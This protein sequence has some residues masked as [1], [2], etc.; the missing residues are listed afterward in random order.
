MKP[1]ESLMSVNFSEHFRQS[2][3]NLRP[4]GG[5]CPLDSHLRSAFLGLVTLYN[6]HSG[7]SSYWYGYTEGKLRRYS[8]NINANASRNKA[9]TKLQK[10]KTNIL[11]KHVQ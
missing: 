1:F 10:Y 2:W 3:S 6:V 5:P 9:N 8:N 11:H 7:S 4:G